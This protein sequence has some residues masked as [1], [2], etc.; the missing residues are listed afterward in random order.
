MRYSTVEPRAS[1]AIWPTSAPTFPAVFPRQFPM[2]FPMYPCRMN[3][4]MNGELSYA[5]HAAVHEWPDGRLIELPKGDSEKTS[6]EASMQAQG[7]ASCRASCRARRRRRHKLQMAFS[8]SPSL[9]RLLS[10]SLSAESVSSVERTSDRIH[11]GNVLYVQSRFTHICASYFVQTNSE[12]RPERPRIPGTLGASFRFRR[13][14]PA[15]LSARKGQQLRIRSCHSVISQ[16]PSVHHRTPHDHSSS[17][18]MYTLAYSRHATRPTRI[19]QRRLCHVLL[20][21]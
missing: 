4:C 14:L 18:V 5:S 13:Q 16:C 21:V 9:Y 6:N 12:P 20:S 19:D 8:R 15:Q 10:A 2:S 1:L 11:W 7:R 3:S 17:F